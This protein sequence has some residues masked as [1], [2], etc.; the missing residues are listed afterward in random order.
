[1]WE[2]LAM[3][4]VKYLTPYVGWQIAAGVLILVVTVLITWKTIKLV[5]SVVA[6]ID[7]TSS[8]LQQHTK[9]LNNLRLRTD[10]AFGVMKVC[11]STSFATERWLENDSDTSTTPPEQS[12]CLQHKGAKNDTN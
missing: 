10:K 7:A 5:S 12:D 8:M 9:E 3:V 6:F 11:P 2:E 4:V 1:M